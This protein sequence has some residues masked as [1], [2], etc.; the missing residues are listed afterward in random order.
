[1]AGFRSNTIKLQFSDPTFLKGVGDAMEKLRSP[2][3]P[4][5]TDTSAPFDPYRTATG[6]RRKDLLMENFRSVVPGYN[7]V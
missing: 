2:N 3:A 4:Y 1:M 6:E 7:Y 5:A